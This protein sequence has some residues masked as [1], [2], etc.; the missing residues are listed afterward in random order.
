MKKVTTKIDEFLSATEQKP[1]TAPP[2]TT[3]APSTPT[4][5][6]PIRRDKPSVEPKPQ[7]SLDEVVNRF[8]QEL[9]KVSKPFDVNLK[10]L[11]SKYE[12][13]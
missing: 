11:K 1:V 3:P 9:K 7:A 13:S 12:N 6:S 8:M 10:K 4:R 5:P 2:K